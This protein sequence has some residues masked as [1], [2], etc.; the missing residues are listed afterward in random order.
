MSYR[1]KIVNALVNTFEE[2]IC[3]ADPYIS[4]LY[5]RVSNKLKF[6]DEINDFMK[7]TQKI[8]FL[9]FVGC[10]CAINYFVLISSYI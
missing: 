3:G 8:I 4:D 9:L 10:H 5:G 6:W 7:L 2:T 1:S